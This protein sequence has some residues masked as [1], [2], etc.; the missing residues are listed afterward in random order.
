MP[1]RMDCK[2][3]P[4]L[5]TGNVA[6]ARRNDH[7]TP[8][9]RLFVGLRPPEPI[10]DALM[11][12]QLGV[13]GARWQDDAQLHLTL[14]FCGDLPPEMADDLVLSLQRIDAPRPTLA[15]AGVGH[16]ERKGSPSALWAAIAPDDGLSTLQ[17][18]VER[19][20]QLAGLPAEGRRFVPHVTLARLNRSSGPVLG[21]LSNHSGLRL[22]AWK[23]E[24]FS[25]FES[26]LSPEGS[27]Y[28]EI[29]R[30]AL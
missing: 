29:L 22:P 18:R 5:W 7:H 2:H 4:A 1:V 28:E 21:W 16:F 11:D 26:H 9:H 8:M 30:M 14:R 19:A 20:C 23:A 6:D 27:R 15:I 13:D 12:I 25:L 10:R 24:H 17:K 3:S